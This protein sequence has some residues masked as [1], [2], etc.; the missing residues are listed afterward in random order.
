MDDMLDEKKLEKVKAVLRDVFAKQLNTEEADTLW[1][2]LDGCP[3]APSEL[4]E[5]LF[6]AHPE[7]E[8]KC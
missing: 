2:F 3:E 5:I 7:L 1:L 6:E 8:E 4:I